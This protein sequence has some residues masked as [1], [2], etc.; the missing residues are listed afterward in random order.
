MDHLLDR[1]ER[2]DVLIVD[3]SRSMR[4][5][6]KAILRDLCVGQVRDCADAVTALQELKRK[7]ADIVVTDWVMVPLDGLDFV[8]ILRAMPD[9]LLRRTPV[10]MV[11]AHTELWRVN[12]ARDAG[13]TEFLAKPVSVR[14]VAERIAAILER[15]R[16]FVRAPRF[17]G[18]C[19]RR[20]FDLHEGPERRASPMQALMGR[21]DVAAL[22]GEAPS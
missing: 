16:P 21:K 14:G 17:A 18:P 2:L 6:L 5:L 3:D 19:R 10:L 15:P 1:L 13:V 4:E 22:L 8:R 12:A 11:T 9:S 7:P 20:R